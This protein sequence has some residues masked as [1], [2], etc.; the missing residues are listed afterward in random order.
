[1]KFINKISIVLIILLVII[2]PIIIFCLNSSSTKLIE[3][4]AVN[5][6]S[7]AKTEAERKTK[8]ETDYMAISN[9]IP[10]I[11]CIGSDL[12]S[13]TGT[14]NTKM[15][16]VLQNKL[17]D[18][19]YRIPIVNLSVPGENT[20]TI[21][22]RIGVIPFIIDEDI[23]IPEEPE[24]IDIE[25]KSSEDGPVWPLAVSADN[26]NFNP[27]TVNGVSGQIGGESER[28][29]VTGENKHYFLRTDSGESFTIPKGTVINTSSD[30]EYKDYV[31][32]IWIGENDTWNNYEDLVDYIQQIIDSCGK[33]KER[34]LVLGL[35][36]G[37]NESASEYDNIMSENFGSHY[38]NVRRYLSGYDLNKTNIT[39]TDNDKAQQ[40]K[41][42]VP[43]CMLQ[44]TGNLNDEAYNI[45]LDFIYNGLIANDCIRKPAS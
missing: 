10:G 11:V 43:S 2:T 23:T 44:N 18:E 8:L 5:A 32:I 20:L 16:A 15:A 6:Q 13:S 26:A 36:T 38:L 35:I 28:D 45:L 39:F 40:T 42:S 17:T 25:L 24:L 30:D 9:E 1:M 14:L 4:N 12:M 21:L 34:Y 22:G 3:E 29:A 19:G 27:V 41:G 37:D 7:Y 31:H 33:N